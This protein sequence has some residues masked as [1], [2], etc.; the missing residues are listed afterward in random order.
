MPI[1]QAYFVLSLMPTK[2]YDVLHKST[3]HL[4]ILKIMDLTFSVFS[5]DWGQIIEEAFNLQNNDRLGLKT[6]LKMM[7]D[8]MVPQE[9]HDAYRWKINPSCCMERYQTG[10]IEVFKII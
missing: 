9:E 4:K 10:Q 2:P 7:M 3:E 8:G 5:F 1:V 6:S